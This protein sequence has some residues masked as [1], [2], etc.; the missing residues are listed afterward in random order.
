MR[1]APSGDDDRKEL[2]RLNAEPWMTEC[3]SLNPAY[4][5][6]GPGED[7]MSTGGDGWGTSQEADTWEAFGP[8]GLNDLNEVA[9]FYFEVTRAAVKCEACDGSGENPATKKIAD[10]FYDFGGTGERWCDNITQD[11][12]DA[13]VAKGRF[14]H[15]CRDRTA[16]VSAEDFN[17]EN[18]RGA[19][20][21]GHDAINR[22]IL[23]ETR[24]KR[25]GVH[26]VCE[27]CGGHGHVFTAPAAT[28]G[29]VL[30]YLHPRKGCSRGVRVKEIRREEL[31][32]VLAFLKTAADRNAERFAKVAKAADSAAPMLP[33][34]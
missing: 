30:W 7:Y 15:S 24:A 1:T 4:V 13:L 9:H 10:A 5:H 22:W 27:A 21:M 12:A 25:L 3:L 23:V 2:D 8:W 16:P 11:E 14:P 6:W 34:G 32:A 26:G 33:K 18:R 28:L 17:A 31:P 20:G 29:I 19:R